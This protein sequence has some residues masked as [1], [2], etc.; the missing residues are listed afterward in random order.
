M[1][2]DGYVTDLI[3]DSALEY[4]EGRDPERPFLLVYNHKAP[5]RNWMPAVRHRDSVSCAVGQSRSAIDQNR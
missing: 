1:R 4:L 3:T 2:E 5:H